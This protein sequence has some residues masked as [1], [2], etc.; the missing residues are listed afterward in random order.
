MPDEKN[1]KLKQ[2]IR[3]KF[4]EYLDR[5]EKLKEHL[6]KVA[7]IEN[8]DGGGGSGKS[9]IGASSSKSDTDDLDAETRKL[10]SGLS[11]TFDARINSY[12]YLNR[13]D[14][15]GAAECELG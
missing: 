12:A 13:C 8:A 6:G 7:Q 4:V 9:T 14:F 3:A 10:R 15:D 1:D 2:L 11:S 5:A